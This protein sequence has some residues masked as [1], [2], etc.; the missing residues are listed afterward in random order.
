MDEAN[1]DFDLKKAQAEAAQQKGISPEQLKAMQEQQAKLAKETNTV[2][3]LNE[4]LALANQAITG[5]DYETAITALNEATQTDPTRDLL[6]AR[7]GDANL[8]S[9][10]KQT[11]TAEKAKRTGRR[12]R[13]SEGDRAQKGNHGSRTLNPMTQKFWLPTTTISARPK[14][15]RVNS[16][17]RLSP[18]IWPPSKTPPA[19]RSITTTRERC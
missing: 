6:W 4:K 8:G 1:L 13:L 15:G 12:H 18:T 5:G 17:K 19:P 14:P 11:D 16:T 2:K 3:A 9:G 10:P 7:L